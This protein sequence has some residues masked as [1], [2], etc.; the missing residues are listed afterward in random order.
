MVGYSIKA[1]G[2]A[3]DLF[4][5][6]ENYVVPVQC[7]EEAGQLIEAFVWMLEKEKELREQLALVIPPYIDRAFALGERLQEIL[8]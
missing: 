2:I 3:K 5:T 8:K 6:Y 4:G 7:L 1:K